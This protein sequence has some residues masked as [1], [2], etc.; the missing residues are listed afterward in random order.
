MH[1]GTRKISWPKLIYQLRK[2]LTTNTQTAAV[3]A[4]TTATTIF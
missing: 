2:K 1:N 4:A 3:A